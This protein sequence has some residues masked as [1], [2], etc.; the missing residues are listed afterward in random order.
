MN[1]KNT[2]P[3]KEGVFLSLGK[4]L[5]LSLF[6]LCFLM[7]PVIAEISPNGNN[8]ALQQIPIKGK[9][10][11][12]ETLTG[13][14]GVNVVVKG[15]TIGKMT[16]ANGEFSIDVPDTKAVLTFTFIGFVTQ[17]MPVKGLSI[18]NV[19][20]VADLKALEEV[21][22]VGY[23]IQKKRDVTGATST[24]KAD[25]IASRPITRVDQ[26]LQGTTAGVSVG[27]NNGQPGKSLSV[28]IR[29]T[30]SITGSNDPLYVIDGFIGGNIESINPEDIESME[31]L[32]DASATAIYGS[33]GSN[34]VVIISTK[35]GS[36]GKMRV[37]FNS[38]ISQASLPK[39]FDLMNA[40]Q[41]AQ[42]VNTQYAAKNQALAFTDAQLA[43][44]K[45]NGPGTDWQKEISQ[46]PIIQNYQLSLSGGNSDVKYLFSGS[47]LDQPGLQ[48][49]QWYKRASLR[50]NVDIKVNNKIDLK[51][52]ITGLQ[53]KNHNTNFGGG[54]FDPFALAFQW[55]PIT[56]VMT[57]GVYNFHSQYA[58]IQI[59]PV[60]E[61]MNLVNDNTYNDFTG[62]G[63]VVY[64][65]T[66]GLTFT[67]NVSYETSF[68]YNPS[69]S[70]P[71]TSAGLSGNGSAATN[72]S[73]YKA[74]Q[75][76]NFLTYKLDI[77][78]HSLTF[79]ALYEQQ[80]RQSSNVNAN[81]AKLS[82]YSNGYYNLG[83][84]ST[85]TVSSG[86]SQDALQSY[87]G[88]VNYSFKNKY[89][90][91]ASIRDDG[92]SHLTQKYSLFPSLALGWNVGKEE[93]LLGSK[94]I[95]ALK[96]RA[97][98]GKTGNQAVGSYATIPS[99]SVGT[100]YYF[101]GTTPS[102]G[103][104]LG[105]AV[106]TDLKWETTS[107]YDFGI[108]A[109][110]L[111][112]RITFTTDLYYKKIQ[113]LLYDY[114]APDYLGGGTYKRNLGSLENKGLE[115]TI[116]AKPV[117]TP[118]FKWNTYFTISFNRNKV[119]DLGG[120]DNVQVNAPGATSQSLYLFIL[121]VGQQLGQFRGYNFLGTYKTSE[122]T[123]A[124]LWGLKPGDAKYTDVDGDHK[125]TSADLMDIGNGTPKYTFGFTNDF[126]Y[127][128]FTLSFMFQGSEGN[129]IF[130]SAFPYMYG[131]L[132]DT[133][134][135][136]NVDAMNMWTP[137]HETDFPI[138]GSTSNYL[139]SNR[140]VYDGGYIKLKNI[141]LS[142][143]L[144]KSFLNKVKIS[145]LEVY[146]SGQNVLTITKYPGYDPE[147]TTAQNAL[148]QGL[149]TGSIPNPRTYTIGIKA[150]F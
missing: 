144:P 58:S 149:E 13:L 143:N 148:T 3:S 79:T 50:A 42:T 46:S 146:L 4:K 38:W 61:A 22:V 90:L 51:F 107:Q 119:L 124:A 57:G 80:N 126:S 62:T 24:L 87:M 29:G 65:I 128:H 40:Y 5:R 120:L 91:T 97:S 23:G 6:F 54:L 123:E 32:K 49:N 2:C 140:Y 53:S 136:T 135:A 30:N 15:T 43:D 76:S 26:A 31:V 74:F 88:R 147:T 134:N 101:N 150:S 110:F 60:S 19:T 116:G 16:D 108:D 95:S 10:I 102:I 121:K 69:V 85:Q 68:T 105:T 115:F 12:S 63:M 75:N 45:A 122:A 125:L 17:D 20:M 109:G 35:I 52:N 92:S 98:Y 18:I 129:Q 1:E 59:N 77:A 138:V 11:D 113:D 8:E 44:I 14:P 83:L 64:R 118:N 21:V 7:V 55:D 9:V 67:S 96:V 84:G 78:D 132:G 34:G 99:I 142:Y 139:N 112:D 86:Y 27:S 48:L 133:K 103:T 100:S 117:S 25:V 106:T 81:S 130:S 131:G 71:L 94:T 39:R 141:S 56:P 137:A 104:P 33:R 36:I 37:D 72:N 111:D 127:G 73:M 145:N 47:Y 66:K 89:L 114:P 41:F 28:R 82:T 70:G 93:F